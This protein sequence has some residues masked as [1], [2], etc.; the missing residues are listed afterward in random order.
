M[1]I[2]QIDATGKTG[3]MFTVTDQGVRLTFGRELRQFI[4]IND[5]AN[6][7]FFELG[8]STNLLSSLAPSVSTSLRSDYPYVKSSE[9]FK[10][11]HMKISAEHFEAKTANGLT[12]TEFRV[13]LL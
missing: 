7:V 3:K 11:E 1:A 2:D 13:I 6:E 9:V 12:T 8:S 5:G 10:F 4:L